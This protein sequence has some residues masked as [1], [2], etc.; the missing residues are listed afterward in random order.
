[1]GDPPSVKRG[2]RTTATVNAVVKDETGKAAT[3][4]RRIRLR[5]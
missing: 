1:V 3:A 5:K 2:K 4:E